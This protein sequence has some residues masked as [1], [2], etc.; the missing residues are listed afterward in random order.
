[1]NDFD[2]CS[3]EILKF[4]LYASGPVSAKTIGNQVGI[5]PRV[6]RYRLKRTKSALDNYQI[7]VLSKPN[8][9]IQLSG[10][11]V[12]FKKLALALAGSVF[13]NKEERLELLKLILLTAIQP[14][15]YSDIASFINVSTSTVSNDVR[16]AR[17]WFSQRGLILQSKQKY[18]SFIVGDERIFRELIV[19]TIFDY[20]FRFHQE[21]F[22]MKLCFTGKKNDHCSNNLVDYIGNYLKPIDFI[23]MNNLLSA[24]FEISLPDSEIYRLILNLAIQLKRILDGFSV[25]TI[26]DGLGDLHALDEYYKAMFY[27]SEMEEFY[28]T[29]FT[30]DELSHTTRYLVCSKAKA[31]GKRNTDQSRQ[32]FDSSPSCLSTLI[33]SFIYYL[34]KK[35]HPS[36]LF[37]KE[38]K[39]NLLLHLELFQEH[40][41]DIIK[42]DTHLESEIINTYP[43]VYLKVTE[44]IAESKLADLR[45][46]N[47]EKSF[48]TIHTASALERLKYFDKR[49]KTVLLV[50]NAGD[51]T[52]K[53]LEL[54]ITSEF[55]EVIIDDVISYKDLLKRNRFDGI[56]FI[57]S[58]FPLRLYNAPPVLIVSPLLQEKDVENLKHAFN[59]SEKI[60]SNKKCNDNKQD[61]MLASLLDLDLIDLKVETSSRNDAI[62]K[63]ARLLYQHGYTEKKYTQALINVIDEFG[64]YMVIWPGI[65]LLHAPDQ[66]GAKQLGMSFIT[67]KK[68]QEFGHQ[69]NDPVDIVI[70]L[71]IRGG[72]AVADA[73]DQLNT[74]LTDKETLEIIR[75]TILPK[76]V[77]QEIK[78][79][80]TIYQKG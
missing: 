65:A 31:R 52:A 43:D 12:S 51:A 50:C 58:T 55:S 77:F 33:E 66:S 32:G 44:S 15:T 8:Y 24:I 10:R 21:D 69:E 29:S 36:L 5:S 20:T 40:R 74:L 49:N 11:D 39:N 46:P 25:G 73:L 59:T 38:L 75:S 53:L 27:G 60:K 80:S 22:L 42:M 34:S 67:L 63:A 35:L 79:F 56:D 7:K 76:K 45:L 48:L 71:S 4:L 19:Q 64:P 2:S 37:D 3:A 41:M 78:R 28:R 47:F 61:R 17:K 13:I 23:H 62:E 30:L 26:F 18:G 16:S 54:K 14:W 57:I 72:E 70:C 68:A 6:V 9:G 1:M